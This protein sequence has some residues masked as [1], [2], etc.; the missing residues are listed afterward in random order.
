MNLDSG[1]H[2][3]ESLLAEPADGSHEAALRAKFIENG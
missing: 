1:V 3:D 2:A